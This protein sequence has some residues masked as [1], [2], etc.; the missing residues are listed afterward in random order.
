[1]REWLIAGRGWAKGGVLLLLLVGV[2][3]GSTQALIVLAVCA[4]VFAPI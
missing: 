3:L 4:L 2:V 1:M